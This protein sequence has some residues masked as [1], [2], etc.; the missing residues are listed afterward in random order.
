[1]LPLYFK[2][3]SEDPPES[4]VLYWTNSL[5]TNHKTYRIQLFPNHLKCPNYIKYLL[6]SKNIIKIELA[7][8]LL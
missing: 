5:N 1:M 8:N 4:I 2:Y 7:L 6:F 3:K